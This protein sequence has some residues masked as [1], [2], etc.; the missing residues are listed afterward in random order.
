MQQDAACSF[1]EE[2]NSGKGEFCKIV[3]NTYFT[4][5]LRMPLDADQ[6]QALNPFVHNVQNWPNIL[7]SINIF[8]AK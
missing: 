1:I 8:S 3:K 4:E 5:H 6:K 7:M 2:R